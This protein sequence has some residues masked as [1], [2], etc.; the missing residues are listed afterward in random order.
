MVTILMMSAKMAFLDFLKIKA[1][2]NKVYDGIISISDVTN[3]I[4]SYDSNYIVDVVIWT[5][6]GNSIIS[7]TEVIITSI[8]QR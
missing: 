8:L 7:M 6:F 2:S 4:L 5:K 1:F 3:K